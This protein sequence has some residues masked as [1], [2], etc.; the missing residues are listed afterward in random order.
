MQLA[1]DAL[2]QEPGLA[3]DQHR[4]VRAKMFDDVVAHD[5]AQSIRIPPPAP[6]DRLLAPRPAIASR[7]GAHAIADA[8]TGEILPP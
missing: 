8:D 2:L 1:H 7:L 5:V 4:V 3:D 6:Q